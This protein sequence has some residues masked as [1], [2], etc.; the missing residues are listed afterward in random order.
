MQKNREQNVLD[1]KVSKKQ[2]PQ[3]NVQVMK[4]ENSIPAYTIGQPKN[5]GP[6]NDVC[7]LGFETAYGKK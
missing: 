3:S 4:Q 2:K 5:S 7:Y 1:L 6:I